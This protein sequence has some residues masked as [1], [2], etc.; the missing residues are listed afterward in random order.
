MRSPGNN[1]SARS[2]RGPTPGTGTDRPPGTS[3]RA[4]PPPLA[5][6]LALEVQA[7]ERRNRY[8]DRPG[9]GVHLDGEGL[10]SA[11]AA[12]PTPPVPRRI[13]VQDLP[14]PA[15]TRDTQQ[16]VRARDRREVADRQDDV[17]RR[18]SQPDEADDAGLVV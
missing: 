3:L 9:T 12:P 10:D 14:P 2:A 17:I 18:L 16:V 4:G 8:G 6:A 7:A 1:T 13:R 15:A 11:Q 5:R